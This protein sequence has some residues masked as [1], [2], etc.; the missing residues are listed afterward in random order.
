MSGSIV[1]IGPMGA[2]KSA[3]GAA[4]AARLARPFLDTDRMVEEAANATI[5]EIFQDRGEPEFRKLEAEAVERAAA[6][7]RAVIACG[8]GAVLDGDNV[9]AL[10]RAGTIVY[11]K[12]TPAVAARRVGSDGRPLLAGGDHESRLRQIIEKRAGVYETAADEEV[13]ADLELEQIVQRVLQI[14]GESR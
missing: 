11:L 7:G 13:D 2:G 6:E 14:A 10:R 12:V 8:G 4:V 9:D 5:E 1:L 3:V